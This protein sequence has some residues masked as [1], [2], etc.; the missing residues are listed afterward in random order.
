M[1]KHQQAGVVDVTLAEPVFTGMC[2]GISDGD[3]PLIVYCDL[4]T[5]GFVFEPV[6]LVTYR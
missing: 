4:Y 5:P 2:D 6:S 3:L 1:A